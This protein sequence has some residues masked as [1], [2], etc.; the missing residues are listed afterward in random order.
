MHFHLSAI[1][2]KDSIFKGWYSTKMRW[3]LFILTRIIRSYI[4]FPSHLLD[5]EPSTTISASH[6]E[7][8]EKLKSISADVA[9]VDSE[10]KQAM[11]QALQ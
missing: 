7:A 4:S 1:N 6:E 9:K 3:A 11:Q 2:S 5:L 10:A 8:E